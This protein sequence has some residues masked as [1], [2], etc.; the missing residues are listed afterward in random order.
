MAFIHEPQINP[1]KGLFLLLKISLVDFF[2]MY[3]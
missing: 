1:G 2:L 3:I